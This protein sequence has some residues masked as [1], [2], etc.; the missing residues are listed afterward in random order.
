LQIWVLSEHQYGST[1]LMD[2]MNNLHPPELQQPGEMWFNYSYEGDVWMYGAILLQMVLQAKMYT[3]E[4]VVQRLKQVEINFIRE[5]RLILKQQKQTVEM[6]EDFQ[7]LDD[8]C[9]LI[10]KCCR[11]NPFDRPTFVDILEEL[12]TFNTAFTQK[13]SVNTP[14]STK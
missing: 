9:M 10:Y 1:S 5:V 14:T 7:Y 3:T 13:I 8:F 12:L 6:N 4:Q 11:E 2:Y